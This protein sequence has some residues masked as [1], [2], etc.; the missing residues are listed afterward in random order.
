MAKVITA[1]YSTDTTVPNVVDDL[2]NIGLPT[3]KI[4]ADEGKKEVKIIAGSSIEAEIKEV[5][6]RHKPDQLSVHTLK[7]KNMAETLT[8]KYLS[9]DTLQNVVDD[10]INIG[11]P[12]E[13]IFADKEKKTVKVIAPKVT[14]AE[15]K[16]VLKRHDPIRVE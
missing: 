2:V 6:K 9:A 16:E 11:L 8:A 14:E 15:I 1:T 10:L 7:E 12:A 13:E 3:E 4:L 5:L